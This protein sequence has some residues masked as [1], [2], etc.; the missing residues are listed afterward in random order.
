MLKKKHKSFKDKLN[1]QYDWGMKANKFM[2][3]LILNSKK[4]SMIYLNERYKKNFNEL[5]NKNMNKDPFVDKIFEYNEIYKN[6][7]NII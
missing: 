1:K 5:V 4:K 2:D 6:N 3:D 7:N